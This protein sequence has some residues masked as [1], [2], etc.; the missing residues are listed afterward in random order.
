MA[1]C[2]IT[3]TMFRTLVF[4]TAVFSNKGLCIS[5]F[6][7]VSVPLKF[8]IAEERSKRAAKMST[9]GPL[10]I[11]KKN[12]LTLFFCRSSHNELEAYF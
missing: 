5:I 10:I 6:I 9:F 2:L 12:K 8:E 11:Y 3:Y 4:F 7:A 1:R